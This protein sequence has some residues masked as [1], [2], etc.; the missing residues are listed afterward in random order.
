M[1]AASRRPSRVRPFERQQEQQPRFGLLVD[2]E[3]TAREQRKLQRR[4][5]TAMERPGRRLGPPPRSSTAATPIPSV[6]LSLV[7]G[8]VRVAK[9]LDLQGRRCQTAGVERERPR[10]AVPDGVVKQDTVAGHDDPETF[11][12]AGHQH[13]DGQFRRWGQRVDRDGKTRRAGGPA[14]RAA[15]GPR[16]SRSRGSRRRSRPPV[17]P[18]WTSGQSARGVHRRRDRP[19]PRAPPRRTLRG[20][21]GWR[22]VRIGGWRP[23]R[24]PAPPARPR[25]DSPAGH[26]A[27]PSFV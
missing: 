25:P 4:L 9:E 13:V 10:P 8:D 21:G 18:E 23:G 7:V 11:R 27:L 16:P 15:R 1:T 6:R 24:P 26:L 2:A 14:E 5:R 3:W 22:L 19:W 17:S 12:P 20:I